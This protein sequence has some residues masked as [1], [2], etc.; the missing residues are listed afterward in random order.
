MKHIIFI[1]LALALLVSSCKRAEKKQTIENTQ[2]ET[3]TMPSQSYVGFWHTADNPPDDLTILEIGTSTIKFELGVF[4]IIGTNGTA[5]IENNKIAFV[6]DANFSG[7][8]EFNENNILLTVDKSEFEYI[9]V[10]RT[11]NFTLKVDK[12]AKPQGKLVPTGYRFFDE[13]HGDLNKDGKDDY[14]LIIKA[15]DKS[16]FEQDEQ[17]GE[18]DRNRRGILI[19]FNNGNDYQLA[20]DNRSCFSSENEDGGE[21]FP[22]ELSVSTGKGN[23]Y[24]AY[25][26]GKYGNWKYTFRYRNGEFVLIGYDA[27]VREMSD[28]DVDGKKIVVVD[29]NTSYNFSTKKVFTQSITQYMDGGSKTD[30]KWDTFVVNRPIKLADIK[31]FDELYIQHIIKF[32]RND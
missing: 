17:R 18:L 5:K 19:F 27:F 16:K 22:P 15:T 31:D 4:K 12:T 24:I 26:W 13:L 9:K 14:V 23:L 2:N 28:S 1:L 7:T 11:F 10:G 3:I 29:R 32:S 30:E 20:L 8:M 6:T 21:Y 25:D